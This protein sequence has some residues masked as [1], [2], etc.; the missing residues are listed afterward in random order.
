[1][2]ALRINL[3]GWLRI[4]VITAAMG[5][6]LYGCHSP[7][8]ALS[9]G[10]KGRVMIQ[11]MEGLRIC[12]Y[13]DPIGLWTRCWGHL[14]KPGEVFPDCMTPEGC[15]GVLISD[16]RPVNSCLNHSVGADINQNQ[17]DALG[18]FAFNLGCG[19]LQTST[20]LRKVNTEGETLESIGQEFMRWD[21][22]AGKKLRGLTLRRWAEKVLYGAY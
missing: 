7:V 19:N 13:R 3:A 8:Y 14:D 17:T 16:L 4:A 20:L 10:T 2:G 18:D 9:V 5:S 12:R 22:A 21:K 6:S 1:M 15:Y 11:Q